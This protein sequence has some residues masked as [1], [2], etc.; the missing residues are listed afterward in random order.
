MRCIDKIL[1]SA[2]VKR[3]ATIWQF[4]NYEFQCEAMVA[5]CRPKPDILKETPNIGFLKA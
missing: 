2:F 4:F 3:L 5:G 1:R